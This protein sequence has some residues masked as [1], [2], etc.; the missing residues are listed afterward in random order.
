VTGTRIAYWTLFAVT[1]AIYAAMVAGTLP[2]IARDAAGLLPFDL[3]PRG[4]SVAEARAFLA[5]LGDR[6][7]DLYLGPQHWLDL[8]YPALLV[9]VLIGAVRALIRPLWLQIPLCLL[10][11]GGMVADYLENARVE[12][13]LSLR[14]PLP[15][16]LIEA[17][18]RATQV[19]AGLSALVMLA[20]C[21]GLVRAG[22][23]RWRTT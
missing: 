19:K 8:V 18:S 6:G 15:D 20:I 22:W 10:A 2:A 14:G 11:I 23:K 12:V 4:Y 17:A 16:A 5:A 13:L 3:R 9:L 7:R 21:A 1:M